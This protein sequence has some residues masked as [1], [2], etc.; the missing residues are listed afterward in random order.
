MFRVESSRAL[1]PAVPSSL[2]LDFFKSLDC[3]S[4]TLRRACLVQGCFIAFIFASCATALSQTPQSLHTTDHVIFNASLV[5]M[6]EGHW[7]FRFPE[8][9]RESAELAL[10]PSD[11][12]RWGSM[13]GATEKPAVWLKDGSILCGKL[14]IT[15][16]G[17]VGVTNDWFDVPPIDRSLVR[18]LVLQPPT[19]LKAWF[20]LRSDITSLS[21]AEDV[22]WLR[23]AKRVSGVVRWTS[24][25]KLAI[26][27]NGANLEIA[28]GDIVAIAFSPAL[29]SDSAD[30]TQGYELGLVDGTHLREPVLKPTDSNVELLIA[31][32]LR[33]Q[34]LDPP[35]QFYR[36]LVYLRGPKAG[37]NEALKT[38]MLADLP[39]ANYRFNA[40]SLLTWDLGVNSD[41]RG[42][43]LTDGN[44]EV[45]NGISLHSSSQ[46]AYRWTGGEG[47]LLAEAQLVRADSRIDQ[48]VSLAEAHCRVILARGGKLE[49]VEEFRLS[50][51]SHR[52]SIDVDLQNAQLI[53]IVVESE[54]FGQYGDE[55]HWLNARIVEAK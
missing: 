31:G 7:H 13:V 51:Q 5:D 9:G 25:S 53:A 28:M 6:T 39:V 27:N 55:V 10:R 36:S 46:V 14:E 40:D 42:E 49:T 15:D 18:V 12:I 29:F 41:V 4:Q 37:T 1:F 43:P 26:E 24:A 38:L 47:K 19:T 17:N 8:V 54:R 45:P 2:R 3:L 52:H 50:P 48:N 44:G 32:E 23:D 30:D 21:G 20:E 33:C 35:Q 16:D 11:V 34:S 22:V